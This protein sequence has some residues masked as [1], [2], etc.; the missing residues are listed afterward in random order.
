MDIDR[1]GQMIRDTFETLYREGENNGRLLL[2][3]L[4]PWL[5]G[6]PFRIVCLD[7]ALRRIIQRQGVSTATDSEIIDWY[8]RNRSIER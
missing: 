8:R 1:Y 7:A 5:I 3:H 6:Q 4:Y 2:L